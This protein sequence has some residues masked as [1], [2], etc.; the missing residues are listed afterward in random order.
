M[1]RDGTCIPN[2][3]HRRKAALSQVSVRNHGPV[4]RAPHAASIFDANVIFNGATSGCARLFG[5]WH[6]TVLRCDTHEANKEHVATQNEL[7]GKCVER[8]RERPLEEVEQ[9]SP[10]PM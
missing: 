9:P 3:T 1:Q 5:L 4:L 7:D 10:T 6:Q 2:P 8:H